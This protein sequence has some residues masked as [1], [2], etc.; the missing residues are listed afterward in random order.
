MHVRIFL[1]FYFVSSLLTLIV[2]VVL[3]GGAAA[4]VAAMLPGVLLFSPSIMMYVAGA[5]TIANAPYAAFKEVRLAKIPT[6]RAL[7]NQLRVEATRLEE[8]VDTLSEEIDAIAPEAERAGAIEEELREIVDRQHF[9]VDR[10]I[11]LVNENEDVLDQMRDNL[12]KK[13]VQDIIHIV[14]KSDVN[15]DQKFCKVESKMLALKIRIQLQE[16]GVEFDEMKFYK[17]MNVCPTVPRVIAIVQK[18]IPGLE[19]DDASAASS[20]DEDEDK[21]AYDMFRLTSDKSIRMS[22]SLHDF[23]EER[24]ASG[25]LMK[26]A[27]WRSAIGTS[28][29]S[30]EDVG[31]SRQMSDTM[32]VTLALSS[33]PIRKRFRKR[34]SSLAL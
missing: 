17:V 34:R 4:S 2:N 26:C 22:G 29:A 30:I 21:E 19:Q 33:C 3:V 14:I 15:N 31:G 23:P 27:S 13:I 16:Y 9:N 7:N 24:R 6:I 28:T 18:L 12:R 10:L 11:D 1:P 20:D 25:A 8:E 32:Q 5:I